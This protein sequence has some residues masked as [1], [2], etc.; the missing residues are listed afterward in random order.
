MAWSS[1]SGEGGDVAV[2]DCDWVEGDM[3]E[4]AVG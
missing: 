2:V 4:S 3:R 1:V